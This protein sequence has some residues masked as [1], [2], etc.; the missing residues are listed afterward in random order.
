MSIIQCEMP[1]EKTCI[2]PPLKKS[3]HQCGLNPTQTLFQDRLIWRQLHLVFQIS[4]PNFIFCF[5]YCFFFK[6]YWKNCI[7]ENPKSTE[8]SAK[9][10]MG[11]AGA[12]TLQGEAVCDEVAGTETGVVILHYC[13]RGWNQT[14]INTWW[15]NNNK[16]KEDANDRHEFEPWLSA[17][18]TKA[19]FLRCK[20]GN[21]SYKDH[22]KICAISFSAQML[23]NWIQI[24]E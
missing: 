6:S 4:S 3:A 22:W 12:P 15:K 20:R 21:T 5:N 2:N 18:L 10:E 17:E 8:T 24:R 16:Q 23:V 14:H 9:A 1:D 7:T 11:L 13:V 19:S